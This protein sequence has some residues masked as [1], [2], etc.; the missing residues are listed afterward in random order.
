LYISYFFHPVYSLV[1][2]FD[3]VWELLCVVL[4]LPL[5]PWSLSSA[6]LTQS[7]LPSLIFFL[8][9]NL[10]PWRCYPLRFTVIA[11]FH[12]LSEFSLHIAEFLVLFLKLTSYLHLSI[13]LNLLWG[14]SPFFTVGF[15]IFYQ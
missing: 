8:P 12:F 3:H 15:W 9:F 6:M 13:Y 10:V 14:H 11:F 4:F 2:P 7:C 5:P 1:W